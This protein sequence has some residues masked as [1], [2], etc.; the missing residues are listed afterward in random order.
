MKATLVGRTVM[1]AMVVVTGLSCGRSDEP[2]DPVDEPFLDGKGDAWGIAEGSP[3]ALAVLALVNQ[4]TLRVLDDDVGLA[5][6]AAENIVAHRSGPEGR[7]DTL[8]ELDAVPYVGRTS[9]A[10]L[11]AYAEAHPLDQCPSGQRTTL[12]G[13]VTAPNGIDPIPGAMVYVPRR[14]EPPPA[15]VSCERCGDL[16]DDAI[17]WTRTAADG[18][19][20]LGPLPPGETVQ[21]VA[22]I[23]W[24]R[25]VADVA[26]ANPCQENRVPDESVR[27]PG[28]ADGVNTI[29]RI[30]VATGDYD[31]IECVLLDFGLEAGQF[32]LYGGL[33]FAPASPGFDALLRDPARMRGYQLI[34]INCTNNTFEGLLSDPAIRQNLRD[35]AAAGGR[36]YV[37]DWS[38]DFLEQIP[39]WSPVIDYEPGPSG[40]SPEP[41]NAAAVGADGEIAVGN[42]LDADLAEWLRAVERRSGTEIIS[43]ANTV[44]I[45]HFLAGW[46]H[47]H[48][49]PSDPH[50]KVWIDAD[51][52]GASHRALTT[53]YDVGQCGRWLYSSYHT[54]AG[55]AIG[56]FPTYCAAGQLFPQERI[57]EYL[58]LHVAGC[59]D[60]PPP[61]P[62]DAGPPDSPP[63]TGCGD[64]RC[65]LEAGETAVTCPHDCFCG[66]GHC[67]GS[68]CG[69]GCP[70]DCAS[71]C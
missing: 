47:Q 59:L 57:L 8:V 40:A 61:P 10:K 53:T 50:A 34:V 66:D 17:V 60:D 36:L 49:V 42:V 46:V 70:A 55:G 56:L 41:M 71:F 45:E 64:G 48:S 69:G 65:D 39:E 4:A 33:A 67:E 27:L 30:A 52:G 5:R 18:S 63:P 31:A 26:I 12:T 35:Y 29:P 28:R 16:E 23:G 37:T 43:D 11:L 9:F 3:E 51:I 21:V 38:Y 44:R 24:F 14:L 2:L 32:D 6:L 13:V 25:R 1:G 7:F 22:Q 68:E 54:V 20:A 58:I 62:A 19:F 15:Q